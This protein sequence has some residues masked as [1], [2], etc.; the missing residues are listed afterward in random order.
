[1]L[2]TPLKII[3]NITGPLAAFGTLTLT[4][5]PEPGSAFLLG[6]GIVGLG[7]LGRRRL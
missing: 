7:A 2:V 5:A 6:L 4:Y 1:V 3:S